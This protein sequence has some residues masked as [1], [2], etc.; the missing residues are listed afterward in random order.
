MAACQKDNNNAVNPGTDSS[1]SDTNSGEINETKTNFLLNFD[2]ME[3]YGIV[4]G[5]STEYTNTDL[6]QL[7]KNDLQKDYVAVIKD[8]VKQELKQ[9]ISYLDTVDGTF[10]PRS[11]VVGTTQGD[12][13]L[14][15]LQKWYNHNGIW[16]VSRY[17]QYK[18]QMAVPKKEAGN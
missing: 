15:E 12:I 11:V 7:A 16:A 5:T 17:A 13:Y 18:D 10:N 3:Q 8:F 4:T 1:T 9:E 6:D 14:I 2:E